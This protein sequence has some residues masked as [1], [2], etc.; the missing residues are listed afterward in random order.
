VSDAIAQSFWLVFS[1]FLDVV[2]AGIVLAGFGVALV[3]MFSPL[4]RRL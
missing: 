3:R 1:S 2:V 4:F